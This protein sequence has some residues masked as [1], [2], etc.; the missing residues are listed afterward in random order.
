[1]HGDAGF[2][3]VLSGEAYD[4]AED[5]VTL[6]VQKMEELKFP[7]NVTVRAARQMLKKANVAVRQ[8]HLSEAVKMYGNKEAEVEEL[9]IW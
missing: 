6:L 7:K 9:Q 8:E 4:F 3:V 1:M 5:R 2:R